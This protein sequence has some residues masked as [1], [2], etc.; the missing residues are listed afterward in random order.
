MN[1]RLL[2]FIWRF[3]YFNQQELLTTKG[4]PL[5]ILHPGFH[6]QNQGPDFTNG[7]IILED[8][9]L[10]GT[11]ELHIKTSGWNAHG[12]TGDRHYTNV[13]LHV[14]W[15]HNTEE[16]LGIPV[17][18][19]RNR[20]PASL[21][22]LYNQFMSRP[23]AIPCASQLQQVPDITWHSWK[24][25]MV[26]ERLL[27]RMEWAEQQLH[28]TNG[29][30]EELFWRSLARSFGMPLNADVFEAIA[31]S[32]P[33]TLL[34]RHKHQIHQLEA[35]L[36]GQ[37]GLLEEKLEDAYPVLLQKEYR[38]LQKKYQLQP[39]KPLLHFLRMR[40]SA[41]PTI[42]LAQ[43]A[44]LIYQSSHLFSKIREADDVAA[45]RGFFQVTAND[46][47][48]RHYTLTIESSFR[49]KQ[50]G[51]QMANSLLINTVLPLLV[52]YAARNNDQPLQEK[53]MQWLMQLPKEKN[54]VTTFW[55]QAGV[56][57]QN[58]FDSQALLQ[59]KKAYCNEL[60]CLSCA[61]GSAILRKTVFTS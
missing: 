41:F 48:H 17:L 13:I 10:A 58:A 32:L 2:Q 9:Q 8:L 31:V 50:V 29:N 27:I 30:W 6:N 47:W 34:A 61:I 20:V 49:E 3:Q 37:A 24:E 54:A 4:L 59:L 44:M 1:E 38:F 35:M 19:L 22:S 16:P 52:F 7:R 28:R 36:L 56:E 51:R 55:E 33:V 40:P 57:H 18:E 39:V 5:R 15:E 53:C 12:H 46:F 11:V 23:S 60:R 26:T 45:L 21:L 25:R 43:L 42:R 14:V